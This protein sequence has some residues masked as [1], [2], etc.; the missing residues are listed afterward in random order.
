MPTSETHWMNE[1]KW[2]EKYTHKMFF[3]NELLCFAYSSVAMIEKDLLFS[4]G[5]CLFVIDPTDTFT[6]CVWVK[7]D[8]GSWNRG[9]GTENR[10]QTLFLEGRTHTWLELSTTLSF[11]RSIPKYMFYSSF[12]DVQQEFSR[13]P[14]QVF[15]Y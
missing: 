11:P 4:E 1:D 13:G 5:L 9:E 2:T 15:C 6:G 12:S 7:S 14:Y 8:V 10:A 3:S